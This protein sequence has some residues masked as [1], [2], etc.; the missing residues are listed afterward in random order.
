MPAIKVAHQPSNINSTTPPVVGIGASA[1]G[2][3][4]LEAFFANLSAYW[5]CFYRRHLTHQ[6]PDAEQ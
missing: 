6:Q 1:G 4:A 3:D 5:L 2:L